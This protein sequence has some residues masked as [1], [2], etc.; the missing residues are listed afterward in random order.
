MRAMKNSFYII[1]MM[2]CVLLGFTS[3]SRGELVIA[4]EEIAD[5]GVQVSW[6]GSGRLSFSDTNISQ[7]TL[8]FNNLGDIFGPGIS[9][10]NRD[11]DLPSPLILSGM[12][13]G[14]TAFE[15]EWDSLRLDREGSDGDDVNFRGGI[16]LAAPGTFNASG[17]SIVTN[18]QFS[19]LIPGSYTASNATGDG[20]GFSEADET[21]NPTGVVTLNIVALTA[22]PE[23]TSLMMFG[24]V[25]VPYALRRRRRRF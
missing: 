10:T 20:D 2:S 8:D 3:D 9:S 13:D 22:V 25:V 1:A 4:F 24:S 17:S 19:D 6:S 11:F 14:G 7:S 5:G 12:F 18:L 15:F 21:G 16:S 23:P